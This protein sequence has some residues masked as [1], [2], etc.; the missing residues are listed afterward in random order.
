MCRDPRVAISISDQ[1][2]HI[3]WLQ[4]GVIEQ[5]SEGADEHADTFAQKYSGRDKYPYCFPK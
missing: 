1:I 5:I 3:T 4:L 2:I